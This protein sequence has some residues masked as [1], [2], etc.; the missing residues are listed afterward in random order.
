MIRTVT[1]LAPSGD[2]S[3]HEALTAD[4]MGASVDVE[5]AVS[6][7]CNRIGMADITV[8]Q[9]GFTIKGET[10]PDGFNLVGCGIR[11]KRSN[12]EMRNF[13]IV[14]GDKGTL[15]SKDNRDCVGLE[16]ESADIHNVVIQNM[17]LPYSVDGAI[18]LY[19]TRIA[20]VSI[21]DCMIAEPLDNA[22]HSSGAHS[23]CLLISKGENV[24]VAGNILASYRYR[25]P[26]IRGPSTVKF[27]NNLLYNPRDTN[28]YLY[29]GDG[30]QTGGTILLALIGNHAMM[31][32][33]SPWFRSS[34]P[35]W[36][37][38]CQSGMSAFTSS[39][40]YLDDNITTSAAALIAAH[41]QYVNANAWPT[42]TPVIAGLGY[43]LIT[44]ADPTG[45]AYTP[46]PSEDVKAYVLANAGPKDSNGD[47]R[48]SPLETRIRAEI[49][50]GAIGSLKDTVPPTEG[51]YFGFYVEQSYA[52]AMVG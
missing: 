6:G 15:P 21:L 50:D 25:A 29:A 46:I 24:L 36:F 49:V 38:V 13:R 48:D 43:A 19:S 12:Q 17:T 14:P 5:F 20:N 11:Y 7:D 23:T 10:S 2:G 8:E 47:L 42:T 1:T 51:R 26:A 16:G 37:E 35:G 52:S 18:D 22:G 3:F 27:A 4:A 34:P 32:P 41:A 31:G 40:V 44:D 9:Q 45:I 33:S 28:W 39:R 30:S